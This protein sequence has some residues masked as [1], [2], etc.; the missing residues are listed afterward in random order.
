[1]K[2]V[3]QGSKDLCGH[4]NGCASHVIT[5][6]MVIIPV[7]SEAIIQCGL[8][9]KHSK[10]KHCAKFGILSPDRGFIEP[11]ELA[12]ARTLVYADKNVVC[13]RVLSLG[14][15]GIQVYKHPHIT[16]SLLL[17]VLVQCWITPLKIIY[18][19]LILDVRKWRLLFPN[20]C[21]RF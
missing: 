14:H 19:K 6:E 17:N 12:L 11:Y 2:F 18:V 20:I 7:G 15:N 4:Y 3:I 5:Y 10:Q 21:H 16:C 9:N 13:V 1:M 8:T